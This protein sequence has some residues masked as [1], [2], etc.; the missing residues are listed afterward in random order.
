MQ[1]QERINSLVKLGKILKNQKTDEFNHLKERAYTENPWFTIENIE[2]AIS[3]ISNQ[4]LNKKEIDRLVEHYHITDNIRMK[5]VGLVLAGNIPLVGFH[6]VLCCFLTGHRAVI[7]MSEKDTILM[8]FVLEKLKEIHPKTSDYFQIVSKLESYD[9]VIATGSNNTARHFEYYFRE[10]PHIIRHN[11]NAV[12]VI[13]GDEDDETLSLLGKDVFEYFG[14]GCR[15]VSKIYVPEGFNLGRLFEAFSGFRNIINHNKYRN[16]YDYNL[17]LFLLNKENFLH[18]EFLILR[19]SPDIISRIACL[20]YEFY[21][22]KEE[23]IQSLKSNL[24]N[25][26][27]IVSNRTLDDLEVVALGQSQCPTIDTYADGTDTIQFLLSL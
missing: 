2:N 16:N 14:L 17:A 4:F 25:I 15:N 21:S 20:H 27:E 13:H 7:K 1:L 11:R 9:A 19:E 5:N 24:E 23:V 22:D 10:T 18:N 3:A 6:D 26:Q 12:G 8:T